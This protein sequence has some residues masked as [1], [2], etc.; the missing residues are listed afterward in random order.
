MSRESLS[1]VHTVSSLEVGGMEQFVL[2]MASEQQRLGHQVTVVS[3]RE[4]PL[5]EQASQLSVRVEIVRGSHW[6]RRW[7]RTIGLMRKA[8]PDVVH[9]HN[10][11]SLPY[12]VAGKIACGAPVVLTRHGQTLANRPR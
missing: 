4:G 7:I 11:T 10:R 1:I 8:R 2:R 5:Q 12:A 6:T 9:C 3:I